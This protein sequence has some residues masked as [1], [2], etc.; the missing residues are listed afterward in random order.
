MGSLEAE[1][2]SSVVAAAGDIA[3]VIDGEGVIRDLAFDTEEPAFEGCRGWLGRRWTETVTVESRPKLLALMQDAAAKAEPHWRQVNHPAAGGPDVPILY[4]AVDLGQKGR[5]VAIGRSLKAVASLQQR[6]VDAQQAMERDYARLRHAETRYR[7]LFQMSGEA[8]LVID[9]ASNRI[10]DSNPTAERLHGSPASGLG[11]R[12]FPEGFD[13]DSTKVLRTLLANVRAT[14]RSD[15]GR[16]IWS[17]GGGEVIVSAALFRLDSA[18]LFLVRMAPTETGG[19]APALAPLKAKLLRILELGPDGFVLTSTD[20]RVLAANAAFLDLAQLTTEEQAR[21]EPL[22]RWLGRRGVDVDVLVAN[23]KERGTVR[24]FST[25]LHG[26][27]GSAI[28]VEVSAVSLI[29]GGP[30]CFGFA[31]RNVGRRLTPEARK[32]ELPHSVEQLTELVGR[33]SLKDLV[34]ETTDMIERLYIEAALE[35]TNDNRASA[36]E[37]L[38]LSR[39]SLYVKLRRYG[40]M[41]AT[42]EDSAGEG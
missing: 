39:Q 22:D 41:E 7:L 38:G 8:L 40:L 26:E 13:D 23:L 32:V 19:G 2:A 10:V 17:D 29:D 36:A 28:D 12:P 5:L 24:L 42:T 3:L 16:A 27:F 34:R 4:V 6:L 30:P 14:G 35:M 11:G 33:V 18:S 21:G 20:G 15:E 1:V 31:I 37:M 9:A 25:R